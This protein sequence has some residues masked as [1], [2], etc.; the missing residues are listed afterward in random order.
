MCKRQ[1]EKDNFFTTAAVVLR[2]YSLHVYDYIHTHTQRPLLLGTGLRGT[3]RSVD[4]GRR[5]GGRSLR[6][7]SGKTTSF[8]GGGGA[9]KEEEEA[10]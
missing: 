8:P 9:S 2:R 1:R 5:R 10:S 3:L 4:R 7:N 6:G